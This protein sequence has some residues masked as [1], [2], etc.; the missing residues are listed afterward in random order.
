MEYVTIDAA[1]RAAITAAM[2]DRLIPASHIAEELD[3]PVAAVIRYFKGP[4]FDVE[5]PTYYALATLL[6]LE[7]IPEQ[8]VGFSAPRKEYL[9]VIAETLELQARLLRALAEE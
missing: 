4:D 2:T 5:W 1:K 9:K 6:G 3:I 7:C 8:D